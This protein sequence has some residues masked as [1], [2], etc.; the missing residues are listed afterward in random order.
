MCHYLFN[1][2]D[3]VFNAVKTSTLIFFM[4]NYFASFLFLFSSNSFVLV[5][6]SK[7][8]LKFLFLKSFFSIFNILTIQ[9]NVSLPISILLALLLHFNS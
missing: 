1:K 7:S 3:L 5:F 9:L 4:S 6:F 8:P 2:L